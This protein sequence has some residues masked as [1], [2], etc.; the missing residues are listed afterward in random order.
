MVIKTIIL[1][2]K[3]IIKTI[4]LCNKKKVFFCFLEIT[5]VSDLLCLK[6][7]ENSYYCLETSGS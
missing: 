3:T 2:I 7:L 4:T 6:I 1:K 5:P